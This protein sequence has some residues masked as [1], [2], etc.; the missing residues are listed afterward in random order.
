M[1]SGSSD[2]NFSISTF[3][4]G[5]AAAWP[6]CLGYI[7]VGLAFG[8]IARKAGLQ[9]LEVG[10]MSLLVYAG[11]SQFIAAAMI[12]SGAGLLP[13]VLT[14]FVVNLRHLLMSSALSL[15]LRELSGPQT[16]LFAYGVTDESF[17]VNSA[18][19]RQGNWNWKT[20]L[21]VN[22]ISN[23]AWVASTIAG[24]L[25]GSFV[26]DGALG[27]DYALTAMFICLLVF[28]VRDSL[29]A[30]AALL[31][32]ILAVAIALFVPGNYHVILASFFAA[33]IGLIL[34]RRKKARKKS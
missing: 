25:I 13:I 20:A 30:F 1:N 16:A 27:L 22:Q 19:F 33:T 9:P 15:H 34:R 3:R 7:A 10:L 11:S 4:K 12:G 31:S 28:Q 21:V 2:K 32:G 8:V 17:A 26:P 5:F 18:L 23:L 29:H 14:T 24:S 6:V